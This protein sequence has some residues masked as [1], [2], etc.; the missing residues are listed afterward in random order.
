MKGFVGNIETMTV[1]NTDFRRVLWTAT[2]CRLLG[3]VTGCAGGYR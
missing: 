2:N 1:D 3:D